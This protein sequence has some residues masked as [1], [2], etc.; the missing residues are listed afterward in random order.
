MAFHSP[1]F[2]AVSGAVAAGAGPNAEVYV[3]SVTTLGAA[4]TG[5]GAIGV[6]PLKVPF[7]ASAPP[8]ATESSSK[9]E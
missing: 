7:V 6:E 4:A 3:S 8:T 9:P 1:G 5:A 2:V